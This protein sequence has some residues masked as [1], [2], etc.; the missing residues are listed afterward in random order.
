MVIRFFGHICSLHSLSLPFSFLIL[1]P[2]FP[3]SPFR[4]LLN[5]LPLVVTTNRWWWE[6]P[7]Q[8]KNQIKKQEQ[9][10]FLRIFNDYLLTL[11]F[12]KSLYTIKENIHRQVFVSLSSSFSP[13]FPQKSMN[14]IVYRTKNGKESHQ[15]FSSV[16]ETYFSLSTIDF[17][18]FQ[19]IDLILLDWSFTPRRSTLALL[20]CLS[21]ILFH[22]LLV[23]VNWTWMEKGLR[24]EG[25]KGWR[26]I[27]GRGGRRCLRLLLKSRLLTAGHGLLASFSYLLILLLRLVTFFSSSLQ[28]N[29]TLISIF[30]SSFIKIHN[31]PFVFFETMCISWTRK[32]N[33]TIV[34][35]IWEGIWCWV[36]EWLYESDATNRVA[37]DSE[38]N[39]FGKEHFLIFVFQFCAL[40]FD[41]PS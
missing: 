24:S 10:R 15:Q 31:Q 26:I 25:R 5:D 16:S 32:N 8:K 38:F 6:P 27:I 1:F 36:S 17:W 11:F 41:F 2:I 4:F 29:F 9:I 7:K 12:E 14:L 13:Y 33:T 37:G 28:S 35:F 20:K 30:T 23:F 3:S 39:N 22:Y 40:W 21:H 34:S 19:K 18:S